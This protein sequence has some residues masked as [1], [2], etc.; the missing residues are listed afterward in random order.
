MVLDLGHARRRSRR[1]WPARAR[2]CDLPLPAEPQLLAPQ[3]RDD[4]AL[5]AARCAAAMMP[6]ERLWTMMKASAVSAWPPRNG[7]LDEGVADEA[8]DRLDLV[9]DDGRD[10]GRLH[11]RIASGRERAAAA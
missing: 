9:L 6:S 5:R 8:A 1:C 4:D 11:V 2:D 10:L 7:R 3:A